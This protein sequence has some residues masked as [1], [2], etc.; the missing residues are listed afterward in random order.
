MSSPG[1]AATLALSSIELEMRPISK[2][3]YTGPL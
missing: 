2:L 1:L 3:L